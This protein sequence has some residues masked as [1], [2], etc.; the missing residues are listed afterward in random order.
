MSES[1]HVKMPHCWKS[2]V[3]VY[4]LKECEPSHEIFVLIAYVSEEGLDE[5]T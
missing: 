3:A 1:T 5:P 2:S 4:L